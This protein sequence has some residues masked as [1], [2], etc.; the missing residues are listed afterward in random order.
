[1]LAGRR[2]DMT[3][4]TPVIEGSVILLENAQGKVAFQL[5]DD[6]PD[7]SY[8]NHWGL[9]GGL[10]ETDE[11]PEQTIVREM[12]EELGL[13][14]DRLQL[15]YLWH[16]R[17]GNVVSHVFHYA[18][19]DELRDAPLSEGQRLEFLRLSNLKHRDVVPWHRDILERY[20]RQKIS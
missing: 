16:Q 9:F 18:V 20:E 17:D 8:A 4:T 1:V 19:T 12:L 7:V 6:R 2:D 13:S 11:S 15:K 14:L 10:Q 3:E 5:R